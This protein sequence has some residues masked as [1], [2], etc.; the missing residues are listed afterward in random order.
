MTTIPRSLAVVA[1]VLAAVAGTASCSGAGGAIRL[2]SSA[3]ADGGRIPTKYSCEGTNVSP[4]LSWSG[5]DDGA[6]EL[7]L[8]MADFQAPSG[9]FHHWIV[10]GIGPDV[11]SLAEGSLPKG[12][13]QAR[14]TSDNATYVGPCP[15]DG[16]THEYLFTIFQ[17]DRRLG[18]ADGTATKEALDA[19]DAARLPGEGELRGR[20]GR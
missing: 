11:R 1:M 4:P 8:V 6:K 19:I 9:T 5:V 3:F 13:V 17:L 10:T 20:F 18:L 16:E 7:A 12:A 2:R 15:P 14:G